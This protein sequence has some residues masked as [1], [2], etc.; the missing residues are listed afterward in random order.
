MIS[1]FKKREGNMVIPFNLKKTTIFNKIVDITDNDLAFP[2][3]IKISPKLVDD[4]IINIEWTLTNVSKNLIIM[5][6]VGDVVLDNMEVGLYSITY[7][8]I[9]GYVT[10]LVEV[11]SLRDNQTIEFNAVYEV[12]NP[13]GNL[14]GTVIVNMNLV[15]GGWKVEL[16]DDLDEVILSIPSEGYSNVQ[17]FTQ[18]NLPLGKY[19]LSVKNL[20]IAVLSPLEGEYVKMLSAVSPVISWNIVYDNPSQ[21][22]SVV[23]VSIDGDTN[24]I[25]WKLQPKYRMGDEIVRAGELFNY[26]IFVSQNGEPWKFAISDEQNIFDNYVMKVNDV[27]LYKDRTFNEFRY[28]YI[29]DELTFTLSGANNINIISTDYTNLIIPRLIPTLALLENQTISGNSSYVT[30]SHNSWYES[31]SA[32]INRYV[33]KYDQQPFQSDVVVGFRPLTLPPYRPYD[34]LPNSYDNEF[35]YGWFKVITNK[36][37]KITLYSLIKNNGVIVSA[38]KVGTY[39]DSQYFF[40]DYSILYPAIDISQ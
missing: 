5:D 16:L 2:G 8:P 11:K 36:S 31:I 12:G 38:N 6:G 19:R 33:N 40:V 1:I 4:G 10:P 28:G 30:G 18:D 37:A 21:F 25:L 32:T 23:N 22:Q 3:T 13:V 15:V 14:F 24:P 7:K 9:V 17:Q 34:A 29:E 20:N 35:N 27:V 39:A 26:P